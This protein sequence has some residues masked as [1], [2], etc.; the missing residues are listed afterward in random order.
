MCLI[1]DFNTKVKNLHCTV[2]VDTE[3]QPRTNKPSTPITVQVDG[4]IYEHPTLKLKKIQSWKGQTVFVDHLGLASSRPL[5]SGEKIERKIKIRILFYFSFSDISLLFTDYQNIGHF[6]AHQCRQKNIVRIHKKFQKSLNTEIVLKSDKGIERLLYIQ[7]YDLSGLLGKISLARLMETLEMDTAEKEIFTSE[8][9]GEMLEMYKTRHDEFREYAQNDAVVLHEIKRRH[10]VLWQSVSQDLQIPEIVPR[11]TIGSNAAKISRA[12]M[13]KILFGRN[14]SGE[15]NFKS[16]YGGLKKNGKPKRTTTWRC[17]AELIKEATALDLLTRHPTRTCQYLALIDGGRCR[18]ER[19]ID[20]TIS[21]TLA[22]IDISGC[23]GRGLVNQSYPIGR[24]AILDYE[25][26]DCN[27]PDKDERPTLDKFFKSKEGNDLV[28]GLW[29]ARISTKKTLSFD[30]DLLLSKIEP[31]FIRESKTSQH[32][33]DFETPALQSEFLMLTRELHHATLTSDL[34]EVIS[35]VCS[36]KEKNEFFQKVVIDAVIFYPK[37]MRV[38]SVDELCEKEQNPARQKYFS[39][40]YVETRVDGRSRHWTTIGF[41]DGWIDK[42]LNMR[43]KYPKGTAKNTL[44]KLIINATYGVNCSEYFDL[45]NVVV[46]SNITARARALAWMMAKALGCFQ[47][48]TD[49]GLF[50]L[51]NVMWFDDKRKPSLKT[52]S[53]IHQKHLLS[54]TIQYRIKTKNLGTNKWTFIGV[55]LF[56]GKSCAVTKLIDVLAWEHVKGFFKEGNITILRENQFSFETKDVYAKAAFQSQANYRFVK[57]DGKVEI[58]ARGYELKKTLYYEKDCSLPYEDIPPIVDCL[59]RIAKGD[60]M[61]SYPVL[62]KTN[63]LK[64]NRWLKIPRNDTDRQR[65]LPGDTVSIKTHLRPI[66]VPS[67]KFQTYQQY[68]TWQKKNEKLKIH[69]EMGYEQF[70]MGENMN[71]S[72]QKVVNAIQAKVERGVKS[73]KTLINEQKKKFSKTP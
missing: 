14:T 50:D 49:G 72:Y 60:N 48:I 18:N 68:Q 38:E 20:T 37:S 24:P 42:L 62:Y 19:P 52:L 43:K 40:D 64:I 69:T 44:F 36:S 71:Y 7:P 27:N 30:Q 15:T 10:A 66:S 58:K 57:P 11:Q 31:S 3:F 16:T 21:G 23:Y 1:A 17:I 73:P 67:I 45:N 46:A 59:K 35:A 39:D 8:E 55:K 12:L 51:N 70:F 22:D 2:A 28:D 4:R 33:D 9:K 32:E 13:V 54:R 47:T 63:P 65:L 26:D 41:A 29:Y 34:L 53:S 56:Y 25:K 5:K 61:K 6:L